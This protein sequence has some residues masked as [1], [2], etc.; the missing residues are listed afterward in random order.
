MAKAVITEV[1]LWDDTFEA[2]YYSGKKKF[3]M[4]D[5]MPQTVK[6]W[7]AQ[8]PDKVTDWRIAT[9]EETATTE[10]ETETATA[11]A[12]EPEQDAGEELETITTEEPAKVGSI[13]AVEP[14]SKEPAAIVPIIGKL[15]TATASKRYT[16][17]SEAVAFGIC[18]TLAYAWFFLRGA[19][20]LLIIAIQ[21]IWSHRT[22]YAEKVRTFFHT[23]IKPAAILAGYMA[24]DATTTAA[25]WTVET[26]KQIIIAVTIITFMV[27][28]YSN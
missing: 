23:E 10:T 27:R 17:A 4:L 18:M 3:D 26:G 9:T 6:T 16:P 5:K 24:K 14:E 25:I 19:A 15:E 13:T 20:E 22:E 1:T 7:I 11:T 12:E 2:R 21:N 8:H 28:I